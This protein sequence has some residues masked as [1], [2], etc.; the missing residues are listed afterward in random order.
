MQKIDIDKRQR[1]SLNHMR[2]NDAEIGLSIGEVFVE[3]DE[4]YR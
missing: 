1:N 4:F 3:Q 2:L